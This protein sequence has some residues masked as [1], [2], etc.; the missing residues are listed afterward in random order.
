[1]ASWDAVA[2]V[3]LVRRAGG[4]VTDLAGDRWTVGARG[5]VASNGVDAVHDALAAC[6]RAADDA[7]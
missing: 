6:A 2:G 7:A 3:H 4:Q 5:L 1:V